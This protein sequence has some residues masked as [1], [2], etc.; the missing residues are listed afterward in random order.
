MKN[1][2]LTY[3]LIAG[4]ILAAMTAIMVPLCMNGTFDFSYSEI[5]GYSTMILAYMAVF[6]GIRNYREKIG[7]GAI[8]FGRAFKVGILITLITSA[9]YVIGWEIV[10][11]NFIPD[12]G[13]KFAAYSLEKMRADGASAAALAEAQTKMV[14]F[15]ELYKNPLF[16]V[17]MTFVE[18][19]P[20]GLIVT[21]VSAAILRKKSPSTP[22]PAAAAIA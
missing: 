13:D 3:G 9:V 2:V 1:I 18:V 5:V 19:F 21:L 7:G 16:N 12:F 15:K 20:V 8:T 17:G 6:L 22:A 10:Y 14:R 11:W 4:G